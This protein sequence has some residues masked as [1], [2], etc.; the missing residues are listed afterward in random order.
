MSSF[1]ALGSLRFLIWSESSYLIFSLRIMNCSKTSST[2]V[3]YPHLKVYVFYS[4]L[5]LKGAEEVFSYGQGRTRVSAFWVITAIF[6]LTFLMI[7]YCLI[8]TPHIYLIIGGP[9][10]YTILCILLD[11][12]CTC[13]TILEIFYNLFSPK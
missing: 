3:N 8:I 1:H 9:R 7:G 12:C 10:Q 5:W 11:L 13:S 2:V 4:N 6:S